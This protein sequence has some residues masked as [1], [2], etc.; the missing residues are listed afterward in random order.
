M[1]DGD[2]RTIDLQT[3]PIQRTVLERSNDELTANP[4]QRF[5]IA[6]K[7]WVFNTRFEFVEFE[8]RGLSL[9]RKRVSVPSDLL[10]LAKQP[11]A[12][13]LLRSTFQL[14]D[15]KDEMSGERVTRLKQFIAKK[16]LITLPGFGAVILRNNKQEFLVAVRA[17]ERYIHRFQRRLRKQLQGAIEANK[18]VLTAALLPTVTNSPPGRWKRFL[19]DECGPEAIFRV[20]D[21]ELT[22]AF[23]RSEDLFAEMKVKAVFKGVTY[24]L[25]TDPEFM[26]VVARQMPLVE[27]LHEEFEVAK[28]HA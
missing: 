9:S 23:G 18:K 10:G 6:R 22:D 11:H 21:R 7:L 3:T 24:E 14:I 26:R 28:A 13:K 19:G 8:L 2:L 17:L 25:L 12:Q 4:P 1:E 27:E 15:A 5:D 16:Y 20:L